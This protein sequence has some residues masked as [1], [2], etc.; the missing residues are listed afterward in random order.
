MKPGSRWLLCWILIELSVATNC[1]AQRVSEPTE[2]PR[3]RGVGEALKSPMRDMNLMR[4]KT[5]DVLLQALAAPYALPKPVTCAAIADEVR[6]LDAALG[7]DLDAEHAHGDAAKENLAL[8]AFSSGIN[9]L[10]PYRGLVR[11]VTGAEKRDRSALAAI[12]AG[13]VR[14]GYLK[15][16]GEAH[17]CL[18]PALP[19]RVSA[20]TDSAAGR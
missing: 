10:I 13:S 7:D 11:K 5:P 19:L 15:G 2:A 20:V 18:P 1:G 16:L 14:R 12:A 4:R 9:S 3:R 17:W 8:N 6:A